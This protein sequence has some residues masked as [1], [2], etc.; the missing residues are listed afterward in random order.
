MGIVESD[1]KNIFLIG[2]S[3][4]VGQ[5]LIESDLFDSKISCIPTYLSKKPNTDDLNWQYYDSR[6]LSGSESAIKKLSEKLDIDMIV[7]ASGAF[8]ASSLAKTS[9]ETIQNVA[10]TNFIAPLALSKIALE[11]LAPAGKIVFLSSVTSQLNIYGS[12]VYAAS[13]LALEKS[14][15]LLGS[16]FERNE[17]AICGIRLGYMDFGMTYKINEE[18]RNDIKESLPDSEFLGIKVLADLLLTILHSETESVNGQ[19]FEISKN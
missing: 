6:D 12:S 7:D 3:G 8:F 19:V 5:A 11:H 4:G 1:H 15:S 9:F 18:I 10:L 14:I 13:K 16:E 2:G 17:L